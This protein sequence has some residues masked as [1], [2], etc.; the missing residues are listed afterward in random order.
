[1]V[2]YPNLFGNKGFVFVFVVVGVIWYNLGFHDKHNKS[3]LQFA[4]SDCH[5]FFQMYW[6]TTIIEMIFTQLLHS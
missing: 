3:C 4:L 1:M 5:V 6:W 2:P